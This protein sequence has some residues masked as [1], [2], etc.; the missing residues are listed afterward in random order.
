[1][2][3]CVWLPSLNVI[4]IHPYCDKYQYITPSYRWIILTIW[5]YHILFIQSSAVR[6]VSCFHIL[7]I[8]NNA[9]INICVQVFVWILVFRS[10]W[11]IHRSGTFRLYLNSMFNFLNN[12]QNIFNSIYT[13]L[14]S[15]QQ[16]MRVQ[17]PCPHQQLLLSILLLLLLIC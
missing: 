10:L 6:H 7:A 4:E 2:A 17:P 8:I 5:R 12:H 15:H 11:Y 16:W 1:M 14:H 13:I 9:I 3:L